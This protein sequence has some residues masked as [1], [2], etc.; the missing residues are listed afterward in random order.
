MDLAKVI[1]EL[2]QGHVRCLL[3]PMKNILAIW[4]KA[5]LSRWRLFDRNSSLTFIALDK[6]DRR[7]RAH[8]KM[9]RRTATRNPRG[10]FLHNTNTQ[11]I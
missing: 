2:L 4:V 11:V 7:T 3:D 6:T 5:T 1:G 9:R 10:Y 8:L